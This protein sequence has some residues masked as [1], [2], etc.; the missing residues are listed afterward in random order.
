[1]KQVIALFFLVAV[2]QSCKKCQT[3]TGEGELNGQ[4][5]FYQWKQCVRGVD[6]LKPN[7][8]MS[9]KTDAGLDSTGQ[10]HQVS[11]RY[12]IKSCE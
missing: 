11:V 7:D 1:M 5:V 2:F 6:W 4:P 3:C 12:T 8:I 9:K 10:P